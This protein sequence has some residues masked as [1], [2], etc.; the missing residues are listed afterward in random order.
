MRRNKRNPVPKGEKKSSA[1]KIEKKLGQF[2]YCTTQKTFATAAAK[3]FIGLVNETLEEKNKCNIALSGGKT[4]LRMFQKLAADFRGKTNWKKINFFWVD[5]RCVPPDDAESN[6]G[7]AYR[8]F[9][10]KL[11]VKNYFR[12]QGELKPD[13]AAG[14]YEQLLRKKFNL[15]K[16]QFPAFDL[17]LLGMGNDGHTASLFPGSALLKEN[18]KVVAAGFIKQVNQN[19]ITLTFPVLNNAAKR[20]FL[21]T[22]EE[23]IK[24]LEDI[25]SGTKGNYPVKKLFPSNAE[26]TWITGL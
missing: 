26:N 23:K 17:I 4:P 19:R 1:S 9:I 25:L 11:P 8:E 22:G 14:Q 2:I 13:E 12:M 20:L 16:N 6:F 5:E 24:I 10:S 3:K 7:N 18:K 21:V 15:K